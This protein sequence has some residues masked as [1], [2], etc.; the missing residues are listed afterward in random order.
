MND[1]NKPVTCQTPFYTCLTGGDWRAEMGGDLELSAA[2]SGLRHVTVLQD[3]RR[4]QWERRKITEDRE[5]ERE[6]QRQRDV[7]TQPP[8]CKEANRRWSHKTCHNA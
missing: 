7:E 6:K 1:Y 4:R 8:R 3:F 2:E 5:K